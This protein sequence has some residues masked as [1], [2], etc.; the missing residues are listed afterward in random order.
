MFSSFKNVTVYSGTNNTFTAFPM[1]G[2]GAGMIC[3]EGCGTLSHFSLM[4]Q[5]DIHNEPNIFSAI[6]I[7]GKENITRILEGLVPMHKV[8]GK[9]SVFRNYGLPRFSHSSFKAPFPFVVVDLNDPKIPLDVQIVGW[10]PFIPGD[11]DNSGLPVCALEFTFKNNSPEEHEC[12]YSFNAF[13]LLKF[14]LVNDR[15]KIVSENQVNRKIPGG[16][17][18]EQH[19]S[20]EEPR[21]QGI[22]CVA[23]GDPDTMVN[24]ALEGGLAVDKD[25]IEPMGPG[26]SIY[27]PFDL[28]SGEEKTIRLMFSWYFP[29]SH[30]RFGKEFDDENSLKGETYK[31]WYTGMFKNGLEVMD[32]WKKITAGFSTRVM[33]LPGHFMK[34]LYPKGWWRPYRR[35]FPY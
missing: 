20:G 21:E 33:P 19:P 34:C 15:I 17:I 6:C 11:Q 18:F 35:I 9:G 24:C 12:V 2:I 1:G 25:P 14:R 28:A 31:P 13:N 30:L 29:E 7:K 23:T 32:Y 10:S 3:L 4:N 16:V 22:F 8:Y 27:V 26:S 5:P